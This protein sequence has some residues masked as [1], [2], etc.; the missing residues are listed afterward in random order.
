MLPLYFCRAK[1]LE[2]LLP[3]LYLKGIS[4]GNCGGALMA[5]LGPTGPVLSAFAIARLKKARNTTL[6]RLFQRRGLSRKRYVYLWT[7]GVYFNVRVEKA[8]QCILVAIGRRRGWPQGVGG[9]PGRLPGKKG[10]SPVGNGF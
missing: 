8:K 2:K 4:T 10:V 6:A 1:N 5:L 3:Y 7:D 9:Q